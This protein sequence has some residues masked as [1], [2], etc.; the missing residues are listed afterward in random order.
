MV[1]FSSCITQERCAKKFPPTTHLQEIITEI[2]KDSIIPSASVLD[3]FLITE[4][5]E[6]PVDRWITVRDT[7]G[8]AELRLMRNKYNELIVEC[9]K[10]EEIISNQTIERNTTNKKDQLRTVYLT[11]KWAKYLLVIS[12]IVVSFYLFRLYLKFKL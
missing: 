3:T 2:V 8:K 7:S 6:L 11:P 4:I 12:V 10:K 5:I 9:Q 1:L